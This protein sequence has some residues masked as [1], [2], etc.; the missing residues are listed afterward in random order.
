MKCFV[1]CCMYKYVYQFNNRMTLYYFNKTKPPA[2]T[3][4]L[5]DQSMIIFGSS[6]SCV[7]GKKYHINNMKYSNLR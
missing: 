4:F 1:F 2:V 6:R 5:F 3:M 7:W